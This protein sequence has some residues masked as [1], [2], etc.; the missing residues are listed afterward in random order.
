MGAAVVG[1]AAVAK[2]VSNVLGV[3]CCC[4]AENMFRG[5]AAIVLGV[6][7]AAG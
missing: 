4:F 2:K 3:Y 7:A 5:G 6:G 1:A